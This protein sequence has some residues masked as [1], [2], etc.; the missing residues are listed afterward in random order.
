MQL[1]LYVTTNGQGLISSLNTSQPVDPTSLPLY[2]GDTV[3]LQVYLMDPL[4][5]TTPGI[6]NFGPKNTAGLNL[7]LYLTNGLD[8]NS[9]S[10]VQYSQQ[11]VWSTDPNN[12]YFYATVALNTAGLIT[13]IGNNTQASA[14]LVIG[15]QTAAGDTTVFEAQVTLKPG[16]PNAN[17]VVPAG[18]TPISL[19]Q[20]RMIFV[21]VSGVSI[22]GG[23]TGQGFYLTTPNGKKLFVQAIDNA[24]GTASL[25]AS[26]AN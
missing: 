6:S 7:M 15:Y 21:P 2:I 3:Q 1:T 5:T 19:E 10:Y 16:I 22:P 13:L 26:P 24:D 9:G 17:I 25:D 12:Q 14:Y 4:Q 11:I 8:S 23:P 20:A 18:L